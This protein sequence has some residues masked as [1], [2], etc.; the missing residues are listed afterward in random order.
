MIS[1]NR[2]AWS[3]ELSI[4]FPTL[5]ALLEPV[6]WKK[7]VAYIFIDVEI[8]FIYKS[9]MIK[10]NLQEIKHAQ[11][12]RQIFYPIHPAHVFQVVESMNLLLEGVAVNNSVVHGLIT[13][14]RG[15]WKFQTVP[16][17]DFVLLGSSLA[18]QKFWM[19]CRTKTKQCEGLESRI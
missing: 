14:I 1:C 10:S 16:L 19:A 3:E 13:Q 5:Y 9:L 2:A 15:D 6:P 7:S 12:G 11:P 8:W 4:G 18:P 17:S